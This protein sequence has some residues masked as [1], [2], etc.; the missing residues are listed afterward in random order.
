MQPDEWLIELKDRLSKH[1]TVEYTMYFMCNVYDMSPKKFFELL[2]NK[3]H[4]LPI[5]DFKVI[6]KGSYNDPYKILFYQKG[7]N[8]K[9]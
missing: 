1:R 7:Y 4:E 9:R 8:E 2:F 3:W 5:E 6:R